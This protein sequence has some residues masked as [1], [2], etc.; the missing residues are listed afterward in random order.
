M[1]SS[2]L[3][4]LQKVL[5]RPLKKKAC[6]AVVAS[7]PLASLVCSFVKGEKPE[8]AGPACGCHWEGLIQILESG[9]LPGNGAVDSD[10][11]T[12]VADTESAS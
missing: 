5:K 12:A 6:F 10:A 7:E 9:T 11:P 1:V 8:F 3:Q 4:R 2:A